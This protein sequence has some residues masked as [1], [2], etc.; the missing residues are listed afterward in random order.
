MGTPGYFRI[1]VE[2]ES[3]GE[4]VTLNILPA[5]ND[6]S[7]LVKGRAFYVFFEPI[8][9]IPYF[10]QIEFPLQKAHFILS[11]GMMEK[12]E[13]NIVAHKAAKASEILRGDARVLVRRVH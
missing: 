11:R 6:F 1:P 13:Y 3:I 4:K 12:S 5:L 8:L 10:S 2:G 7:N 9:P